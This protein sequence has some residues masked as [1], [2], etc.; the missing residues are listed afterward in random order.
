VLVYDFISIS[1]KRRNFVELLRISCVSWKLFPH[2]Y[3]FEVGAFGPDFWNFILRSLPSHLLWEKPLLFF[4]FSFGLSHKCFMLCFSLLS[5][6][7][8][9]PCFSLSSVL[10]SFRKI[11]YL[12][13]R[14][15]FLFWFII[16]SNIRVVYD[17]EN[18]PY[19]F[20]I[21]FNFLQVWLI[22]SWPKFFPPLTVFFS[23]WLQA[24]WFA[25]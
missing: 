12:F 4:C 21:Y 1:C 2:I 14:M 19:L 25:D 5:P 18:F 13:S 24:S 17:R 3:R 10:F 8:F 20:K 22:Q 23:I 16:L 7:Y 9:T 15:R 6:C 11:P